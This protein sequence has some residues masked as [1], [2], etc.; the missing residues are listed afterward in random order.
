MKY[1]IMLVR[2]VGS[3]TVTIYAVH[4]QEDDVEEFPTRGEAIRFLMGEGF[5][6]LSSLSPTGSQEWVKAEVFAWM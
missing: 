1:A 5:T 6:P 2:N 3:V 4:D